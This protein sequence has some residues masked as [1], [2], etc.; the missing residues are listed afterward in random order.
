MIS[1]NAPFSAGEYQRRIKKTRVAMNAAGI[2]VLFVTDPSNQAWLTGYDGW[3]FYTHQGVILGLEGDP[4]W[5]GRYMDSIGAG[6]TVWMNAD[7]IKGYADHYVQSTVTHPMEDLAEHL[8][9]LGF[10][11]ARI[12]VEMEN[13]YYSAKAH[14]VLGAELPNATLVDA[15]ALVNWQRLVKSEDEI[16]FIRKAA[17]ISEKSLL[18]RLKKPRRGCGK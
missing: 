5:W 17:R 7:H 8:Q 18:P 3:S 6:R 11:A 2:D 14:S 16:L 10:E 12:G 9:S 1:G 4:V 15:T 13:Y